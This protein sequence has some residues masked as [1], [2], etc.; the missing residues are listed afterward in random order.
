MQYEGGTFRI[1]D[2]ADIVTAHVIPGP[3]IIDGLELKGLPK[4]KGLLLVAEMSS[5]GNLA[6][7]DYTAAAMKF[8]EQHSDFVIGFLS[9]NPA[10]WPAPAPSPAFVQ[11]TDPGVDVA[12]GGGSPG[13]QYDV[14]HLVVNERGG[15]VMVVGRGVI[16]A[17]DPA[18]AAREY[19]ARGWQAYQTSLSSS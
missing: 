4:G 19:R 8:A 3:G 6:H 11:V 14:P 15:D 18:G 9:V 10:S 12:A 16:E 17:S 5:P 1:S 13:H 7:G 2:W